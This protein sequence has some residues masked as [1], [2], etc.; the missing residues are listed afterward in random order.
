MGRRQ[1]VHQAKC[2]SGTAEDSAGDLPSA[3]ERIQQMM[4]L[5]TDGK[6]P[7]VIRAELM[8]QIVIRGAIRGVRVLRIDLG[9]DAVV[10]AVRQNAA[11]GDVVQSVAVGV[12]ELSG[13]AVPGVLADRGGEAIVIGMAIVGELLNG[14][15]PGVHRGSRQGTE[16]VGIEIGI[17]QKKI[18]PTIADVIDGG[19]EVTAKGVL[20]LEAAF[21]VE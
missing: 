10:Q 11:V 2:K 9:Q 8:T 15:N 3:D 18:R 21:Q 19:R 13:E 5:N 1:T 4:A 20:Q 17:D 7:N 12:A 6:V 14:C 16:A